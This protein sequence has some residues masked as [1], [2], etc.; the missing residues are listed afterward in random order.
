MNKES[1]IWLDFINFIVIPFYAIASMIKPF[2]IFNI[3]IVNIILDIMIFV[4]SVITF[5]YGLKRR[6]IAYY[7]FLIYLFII[8]IIVIGSTYH[9]INNLLYFIIFVLFSGMIWLIPNYIYMRNR[10]ALFYEH[11]VT[12]IKKCPGCNRIIPVTMVSCGKCNY[13]EGK[14]GNSSKH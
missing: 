13:K 7:L 8:W 6:K 4:Y 14:H 2:H 12:H 3:T 9:L 11:N 5:Y 1:T 10:K